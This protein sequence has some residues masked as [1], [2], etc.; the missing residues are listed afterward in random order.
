MMITVCID[1]ETAMEICVGSH[2]YSEAQDTF[3]EWED[4]TMDQQEHYQQLCDNLT[5]LTSITLQTDQHQHHQQA[6]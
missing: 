4:L 6:A 2:I 5:S 1:N 3:S